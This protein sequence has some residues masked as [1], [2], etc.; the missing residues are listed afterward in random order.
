[1]NPNNESVIK[2]IVGSIR[3]LVRTVYLDSQNMSRQFGLTGQQGL[4]L[5]LL[6]NGGSMSSA[7]LSRRM[8]VT[9]SN[10]TGIIDRLE[11]KG[12]VQR[13]RK[14]G[15]RRVALITLTDA[16]KELSQNVPDPIEKR[17]VNQLIDLD[18]E[19]VQVIYQT[20]NQILHLIDIKDV[21]ETFLELSYESMPP[22]QENLKKEG[23]GDE[24][25]QNSKEEKYA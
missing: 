23:V 22:V 8:Y 2:E 24:G 4:V 3:K 9:P 21:E 7:S 5:H 25:A 17:L 1:M 16:G 20:I 19:H 18:K 12:L 6:F 14:E 11:R 10:I 13:V 15:D